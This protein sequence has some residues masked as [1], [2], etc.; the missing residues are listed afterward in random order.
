[1]KW[2]VLFSKHCHTVTNA[3]FDLCCVSGKE[4]TGEGEIQTVENGPDS[5]S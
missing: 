1:M 5:S 3:E 4:K 2:N